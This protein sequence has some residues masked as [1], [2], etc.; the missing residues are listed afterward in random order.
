MPE[1][2]LPATKTPSPPAPAWPDNAIAKV[3]SVV[4]AA[5]AELTARLSRKWGRT[6]AMAIATAKKATPESIE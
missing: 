2:M 3:E 1:A 5:N 6:R 4:M